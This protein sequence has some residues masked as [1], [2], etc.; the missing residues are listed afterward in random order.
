M[1]DEQNWLAAKVIGPKK[2]WREYKRRV[3]ALPTPYATA[4][5][6]I[7]RYLMHFGGVN[8]AASAG[9]LFDDVIELFEQAA[10]DNTPIRDVVGDDPVEFADALIRNYQQTGYVAR[11]RARLAKSIDDAVEEQGRS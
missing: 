2:Q 10:A 6:G 5:A 9:A 1:S 3:K 4:V 8:D 7:E 11:E